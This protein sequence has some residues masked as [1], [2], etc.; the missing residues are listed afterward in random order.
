MGQCNSYIGKM[1]TPDEGSFYLCHG[2]YF[3]FQLDSISLIEDQDLFYVFHKHENPFQKDSIIEINKTGLYRNYETVPREFFATAIIAE[4]NDSTIFNY[5][6]PCMVLSNTVSII[7]LSPIEIEAEENC[8]SFTGFSFSISGGLPEFLEDSY[9][10]VSGSHFD[11]K[12]KPNESIDVEIVDYNYL[13]QSNHY[14]YKYEI[15]ASDE[16]ECSGSYLDLFNCLHLPRIFDVSF[17]GEQTETGVLLKW[18]SRHQTYMDS[19]KI[20]V[21]KNGIDWVLLSTLKAE[22]IPSEIIEYE[23]LDENFCEIC[24]YRLFLVDMDGTT[25]LIDVIQVTPSNYFMVYPTPANNLLNIEYKSDA[26]FRLLIYD[27]VGKTVF[28]STIES[29]FT[30]N[31][32]EINISHLPASIYYLHISS[33]E[34]SSTQK[35]VIQR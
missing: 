9:Y 35:F 27:T 11:G 28:S 8:R 31:Q 2:V 13:D 14:R 7:N 23:F 24:Y 16:N 22:G 21:S 1:A 5:D 15:F 10:E 6:D 4:K 32:K 3:A 20:E 34:F 17:E 18:I 30:Y 25:V 19:Y 12:I 26:P 29:N 33:D